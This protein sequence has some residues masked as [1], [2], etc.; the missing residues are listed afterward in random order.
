MGLGSRTNKF[1]TLN[2][3]S[4]DFTPVSLRSLMEYNN[5]LSISVE[6]ADKTLM[7]NEMSERLTSYDT[8]KDATII[9]R[10]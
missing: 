9:D 6:S 8:K 10:W 3:E 4:L 1:D 7:L 2:L 5:D